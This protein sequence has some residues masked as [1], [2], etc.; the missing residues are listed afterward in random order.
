MTTLR[1]RLIEDLTLRGYAERTITT[2]VGVVARLA[3]FYQAKPDELT[4][5][6]IRTYLLDLSTRLAP[7][8]VTQ[9]LSGL[10]FFYEQTLGRRWSILDIARAKR[11]Q[12]LPVVLSREEVRRVLAAVQVPAYRACLTTIYGCGLRLLEGVTL[13]VQDIDGA[14]SGLHV[15]HGKG[16]V[17]RIVPLPTAVLEVLRAHWR[18][19]RHPQWLFPA[20]SPRGSLRRHTPARRHL[21]PT[22]LQRAFGQAVAASKV[23]KSA[24]IYIRY[25]TATPRTC[26]RPASRSSSFSNTSGTAVRVRRPSTRTSRASCATRRGIRSTVC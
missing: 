17:D 1:Q 5:E 25:A 7:A 10:R 4:E 3:H 20:P 22:T 16:G 13:T 26:S 2:Y 19:H 24:R 9:A 6:Q 18:T 12:K 15:H 23:G 11:D 21:H 8:S 14:R